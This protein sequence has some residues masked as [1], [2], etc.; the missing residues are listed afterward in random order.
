MTYTYPDSARGV[1]DIDL[2]LARGSFTVIT[3]RSGAGKT[4]FLRVLLGLLPREGGE[5]RW[6]GEIVQDPAS[7][8][9]PPRCA[10]V[11]QVPVRCPAPSL[12]GRSPVEDVVASLTG[13][14]TDIPE[15]LV[16][17]DLSGTVDA[18]T[19]RAL[20]DRVFAHRLFQRKG[21]CLVVSTRRPA[22]RRADR[23]VVLKDGRLEAEGRLGT[24][25]GTCAEMRR[26][27][28]GMC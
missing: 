28:E 2:N 27:W 11:A 17:D 22:L 9:V 13:E 19:E 3:G 21:A 23:I 7:F 24:L 26:L 12:V 15:L 1:V 4:T 6:N 16:F 20:W 18:R 5:M 25:L 10:Y 14:S 8:F